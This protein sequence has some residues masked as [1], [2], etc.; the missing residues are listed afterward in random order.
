MIMISHQPL[1]K[2][3]DTSLTLKEYLSFFKTLFANSIIIP[4]DPPLSHQST[5]MTTR[6]Y[7]RIG[8]M[9][10][11]SD[12]FY[13]KTISLLISN[14]F[15]EITLISNKFTHAQEYSKI[16]FFHS[17]M[18]TTFLFQSIEFLSILS[19]IEGYTNANRLF[20]PTCKVF[21]VYWKNNNLL[22]NKQSFRLFYEINIPRQVGLSGSSAI[23]TALWKA[24]DEIL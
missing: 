18:T 21:F 11:P 15:A 16:E 17:I 2:W 3:K 24:F 8:L 22:L 13:G 1:F 12:G 10:N 6:S 23:I 19:F 20:Q 14:F 7:A 9:G 4:K 5:S